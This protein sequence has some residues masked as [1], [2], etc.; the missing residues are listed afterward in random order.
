[1]E[2]RKE[3]RGRERGEV[4][5][6]CLKELKERWRKGKIL[7]NWEEERRQFLRVR[8]V[9]EGRQEIVEYKELGREIRVTRKRKK[10]R[11]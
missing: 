3:I 10:K 1:M 8:E 4:A 7:G 5:R 9:K 11:E 6:K 2:A